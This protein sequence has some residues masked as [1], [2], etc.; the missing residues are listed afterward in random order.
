MLV[1]ARAPTC[2]EH[3]AMIKKFFFAKLN[4]IV[5]APLGEHRHDAKTDP[6]PCEK[7]VHHVGTVDDVFNEWSPDIPFL[8]ILVPKNAVFPVDQVIFETVSHDQGETCTLYFS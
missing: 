8:E 2:P 6:Q 3:N 7:T 1:K 5:A 4:D